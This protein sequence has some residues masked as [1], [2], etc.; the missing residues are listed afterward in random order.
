[1]LLRTDTD[2]GT[3]V[4]KGRLALNLL[5]GLERGDNGGDLPLANIEVQVVRSTHIVGTILN[6]NDL[7][8]HSL[9]LGGCVIGETHIDRPINGDS[10]VIVDEDEVVKTEMTSNGAS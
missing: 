6:L 10:V 9:E 8:A 5:G 4:D 7:P 3:D 2:N 1:M